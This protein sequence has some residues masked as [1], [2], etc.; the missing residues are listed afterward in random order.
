MQRFRIHASRACLLVL[1]LAALCLP[2]PVAADVTVN[3]GT[4]QSAAYREGQRALEKEDWDGASKIFAKIAASKGPETDG[5]LYWKAYADWKVQRKKEAVEGLRQLLTAYPKSPWADDAKALELE[6]RGVKASKGDENVGDEELKLYALD[7]LMQVEPEKAVPVLEKL[8]A[9]NSSP[10]IQERALFVLSQ[11]QSPRAREVLLR[12][13]RSGSSIE[14][15]RKAVQTLGIAGDPDDLA[16][17][18]SIA[19]DTTAPQEVREAVIDAYIIA[20]RNGELAALARS[21]P[22][23]HLRLKAIQALGAIGGEEQLRQLFETEKD[24]DLKAKLLESLGVAGDSEFLAKTARETQDP[25]LRRKAIEGLGI[26]SGPETSRMLREL[27][28]QLTD[29]ADKRKVVEA[30]MIH[31]DAKTLVEL[32]RQEKDPDMKKKIL[33]TLS[34]MS[35]PEATRVILEVLGEK[36]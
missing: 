2:S 19:K 5:A 21:D 35:D 26:A 36:P 10:R 20:S 29:P 34:I 7:G 25:R 3:A 16:A 12:T 8:L 6:I 22:D 1:P 23:P 30:F 33:Q 32:F 13:A 4:Q 15:R 28:T 24:P 27:Y 14:L 18:A 31:G 9:G 17:L 11:S